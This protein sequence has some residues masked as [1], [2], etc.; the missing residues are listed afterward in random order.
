VTLTISLVANLFTAVFISHLLF[1]LMV[2]K[3]AKKLSI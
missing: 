3:S 2:K 1:D